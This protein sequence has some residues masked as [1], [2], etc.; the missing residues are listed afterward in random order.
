MFWPVL[1]FIGFAVDDALQGTY[2]GAIWLGSLGVAALIVG[3]GRRLFDSRFYAK[4]YQKS[5]A[6]M[7]ANIEDSNASLKTAPGL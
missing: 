1:V 5:G 3:A 7:I 6:R 4:V 2:E